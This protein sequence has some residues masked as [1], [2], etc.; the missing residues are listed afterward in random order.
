MSGK[1]FVIVLLS[2]LLIYAIVAVIKPVARDGWRFRV[3]HLL[4]LTTL[5][6]IWLLVNFCIRKL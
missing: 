3:S 4:V 6:A 1:D 5:V 2:G